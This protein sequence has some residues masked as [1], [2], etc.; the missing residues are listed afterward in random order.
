MFILGFSLLVLAFNFV[1]YCLRLFGFVLFSGLLWN[2]LG[3]LVLLVILLLI[4]LLAILIYCLVLLIVYSFWLVFTGGAIG[5]Y[6]WV[7][8]VVYERYLLLICVN[9]VVWVDCISCLSW[10]SV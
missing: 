8:G 2:L 9:F 3:L 7:I 6:L 1:V 4:L 5:G 10:F